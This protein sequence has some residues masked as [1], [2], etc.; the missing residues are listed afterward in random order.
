MLPLWAPWMQAEPNPGHMNMPGGPST[1][2]SM[3]VPACMRPALQGA[4]SS[5]WQAPGSQA[6]C[7]VNLP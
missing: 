3:L 7:T 1:M 2:S 5:T 4:S 6:Q